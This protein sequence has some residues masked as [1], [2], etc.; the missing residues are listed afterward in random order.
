M[1]RTILCALFI[2]GHSAFAATPAE[3]RQMGAAL[4][5]RGLYAKAADY[6]QQ[7]VQADPN[8][9]QAYEDLGN[10]R[11]KL[12]ESAEALEAYRQSLRIHPDNPTLQNLV[13]N[14]NATAGPDNATAVAP[15]TVPAAAGAGNEQWETAQP[16]TVG[17]AAPPAVHPHPQGPPVYN[18]GLAA[19]DH[20]RYWVQASLGYANMRT[21]DLSTS[22]AAWNQDIASN[23]WTGS[24]SSLNDAVEVG[25]QLGL[26]LSPNNGIALGVKAALLSDYKLN[27][28]Y[29]N[30]PSPVTVGGNP[31]TYSDGT[32]VIFDSDFDQTT[33]TPSLLP[34][35]LDYYLFLP[36]G[37]GRFFLSGGFGWYIGEVHAE[38]AYS[39]VIATSDPNNFDQWS[40]DLRGNGPGF[41]VRLGREFQVGPALGLVVYVGGQYAKISHFTGTVTDPDG[42][43]AD[44]GLAV[45][46][47]L[48]N[49]I[50]LED[51]TQI[52][53]NGN[54]YATIDF[55]A[56]DAG[57][58]LNWYSF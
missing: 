5:Q 23:G 22:A 54:D 3:L 35:T 52:G 16:V 14:L 51:V 31:V 13:D 58:A 21:G 48:N 40:G 38:R 27:V 46:P 36:D 4:A 12:N 15:S 24:A 45:E 26:L 2:L 20:A 33:L 41:Q 34:I 29:Q 43:S 56:V 8:D 1:K 55:T 50:F 53:N 32:T 28:N 25:G 47:S 6:L 10:V 49:R 39:A 44:V 7:A 37:G 11:M 9:W 30:G 57:F 42:F 19:I 17:G 18:D